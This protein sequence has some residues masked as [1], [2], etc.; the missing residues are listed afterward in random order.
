MG[1]REALHAAL[2]QQVVPA[3]TA[4]CVMAPGPQGQCLG[5]LPKGVG[6]S[7]HGNRSPRGPCCALGGPEKVTGPSRG[8]L[9]ELK[10][11]ERTPPPSTAPANPLG[12]TEV[13]KGQVGSQ[14]SGEQAPGPAQLWCHACSGLVPSPQPQ[15]RV[16]IPA[17]SGGYPRSREVTGS[18]EG[19]GQGTHKTAGSL[20]SLCCALWPSSRKPY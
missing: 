16:L 12:E 5:Y 3:R 14:V 18:C 20:G 2:I 7:W 4:P 11:T 9:H 8:Q 1:G 19:W 13:S 6:A 15:A 10:G 17:P